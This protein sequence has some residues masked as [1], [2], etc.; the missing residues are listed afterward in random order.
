[1]QTMNQ[2]ELRSRLQY[3]PETGVFVWRISPRKGIKAGAV[4]GALQPHGYIKIMLDKRLYYAHRLVWLY[5]HGEIPSAEID[6]INGDRSDNRLSNLRIATRI[7]N[8]ANLP[9]KIN[10]TSGVPGVSWDKRDRRWLAY[11]MRN[12]RKIH[13][14]MSADFFEAVCMRKAAERLIFG[15]FARA[16]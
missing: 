10:N 13:L 2:E 6:H 12:R 15:E 1:M 3:D 16:H 9:R 4:A 14:G 11:I 7:E 5:V 8:G